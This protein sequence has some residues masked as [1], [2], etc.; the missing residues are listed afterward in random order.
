M[1]K[2]DLIFEGFSEKYKKLI[3]KEQT[4]CKNK[5]CMLCQINTS[6]YIDY[7][8]FDVNKWIA[9]SLPNIDINVITQEL[10][11]QQFGISKPNSH[12]VIT[13]TILCTCSLMQSV[14][15]I[16]MSKQIILSTYN[17]FHTFEEIDRAIDNA[18]TIRE[19]ENLIK[20]SIDIFITKNCRGDALA[21]AVY[22]EIKDAELALLLPESDFAYNRFKSCYFSGIALAINCDVQ[23]EISISQFITIGSLGML[24]GIWDDLFDII[25]DQNAN[26]NTSIS[27]VTPFESICLL[28]NIIDVTTDMNHTDISVITFY[29]SHILVRDLYIYLKEKNNI[30]N[31][32][33]ESL[34]NIFSSCI[35]TVKNNDKM[36]IAPY[37][38]LRL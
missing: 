10:G 21:L 32:Y 23:D 6:A 27:N 1:S 26:T 35:A 34:K 33:C 17:F 24:W 25:E 8:Q 37:M 28:K 22:N 15:N 13:Y 20:H 31:D 30:H 16:P 36:L 7:K 38:F 19:K 11:V 12:D 2:F 3:C 9:T 18:L 5:T 14:L 4:I 29:I